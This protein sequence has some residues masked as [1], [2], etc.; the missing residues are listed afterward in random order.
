MKKDHT[1]ALALFLERSIGE[2]QPGDRWGFANAS[3]LPG[4]SPQWQS[5]LTCQQ[6]FRPGFLQL[7]KAG[8]SVSTQ[9]PAIDETFRGVVFI[10]SRSR[11]WNE[12]TLAGAWNMLA[13]GQMLVVAGEKNSG[14]ASLRK[15]MAGF[16][17]ITESFSKHHAVVF[18]VMRSPE[19]RDLPQ[20]DINRMVDGYHLCDGVFSADGAD[21]GSV[22]L[23]EHMSERV[24]GRVADLGAGWGYLSRELLKRSPN[25]RE[26]VLFEAS[27]AALELARKNLA[28][29]QVPVSFNWVDITSEFQKTPYDWVVMNPPFHAGRATD[30]D[31]G[32]RFIEVAASTLPAGGRLLMVANRNLPYEKT[33][34]TRFRRFETLADLKGFKILEAVK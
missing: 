8:Y 16:V 18:S 24:R 15:W 3:V 31:L 19:S 33:L 28:D 14:I 1:D 25:V 34:E 9:F 29:V 17:E 10:P 11:R 30:P 2:P 7:E 23:T 6:D 12:A 32:K 21:A 4:I 13:P 5:V 20:A 27:L 22:L 26:L